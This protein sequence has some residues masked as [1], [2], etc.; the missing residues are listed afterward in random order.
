MPNVLTP[1]AKQQ[2]FDNNGRPL[3]GG[4]LFTYAAGTSSKRT[5]YGDSSLSLVN[6]NPIIL[7]FRGE[8]DVWIPPN[9]AYKFVLSPP[10]DTDPP[11]Q[12]IWTV[13]QIVENQLITLYGGIDSG[14]V[15]AYVLT[16]DA[17]FASYVDGI[18]IYWIPSST[19]TGPS[20]LNVNGLGALPIADT[21][22]NPLA[23]G[24]I[25]LNQMTSVV[26]KSGVW[27]LTSSPAS[28]GTFTGTITGITTV[29]AGTCRY[30]LSGRIVAVR[31]PVLAGVSNSTACTLTGVPVFLTPVNASQVF[32][33]ADS[34][35]LDNSATV[36]NIRAF[37]SP[38]FPGTITFQIGGN[39]T[40][41]TAAG[42]K[43]LNNDITVMWSIA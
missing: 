19:N 2:F 43:G 28:S 29:E 25:V 27:T 7:N 23:P 17:S 12:S 37:T 20:T 6:A 22:G 40:G 30:A 34:S 38:A 24:A 31:I 32:P 39:S 15:N 9:V 21:G 26:L 36:S 18:V 4:K 8:C 5:T 35:F 3:V 1:N 10:T 14:S 41:F 33:V 16:F 13:D 42:A 11:T